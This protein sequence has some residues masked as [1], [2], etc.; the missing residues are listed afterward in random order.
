MLWLKDGDLEF[1]KTF[2]RTILAPISSI[3]VLSLRLENKEKYNRLEKVH[4][5]ENYIKQTGTLQILS[6][7]IP[8][9]SSKLAFIVLIVFRNTYKRRS[10]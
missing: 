2:F 10:V 5:I 8:L 3:Q 6:S 7:Q 9:R 4:K 1:L